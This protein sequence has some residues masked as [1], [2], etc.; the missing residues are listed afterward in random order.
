MGKGILI[1]KSLASVVVLMFI[2]CAVLPISTGNNS[3]EKDIN[4]IQIKYDRNHFNKYYRSESPNTQIVHRTYSPNVDLK[5]AI[6]SPKILNDG[7]L[8]SP[9]PLYCHDV[10]HT[11]R[12]PYNTSL[13]PYVEMWR[14]GFG[15]GTVSTAITIDNDGI[16]YV[17]GWDLYAFYPNGTL[18]WNFPVDGWLE[19]MCPAIADDGTI[20]VGSNTADRKFF[21][22]IN[23]NGT[24]KWKIGNGYM[25][26]TPIIADDGT[27]YYAQDL[28]SSGYLTAL[29][30]NGTEKWRY[31][32]SDMPIF[33]TP[34]LGE[35]GTIYFGSHDDYFYA[36]NPN[37]TLKWKYKTGAWIHCSPTIGDDGSIYVSS[38][39]D[40]LYAFYPNGTI[41]WELNLGSGA[42][43]A[44]VL[45]EDGT[46]Y[47][48]VWD[49]KFYAITP[50]GTVKWSFDCPGRVWHSS[51][52]LSADGFI[53]FGTTSA[54]DG[55]TGRLFALNR[56]G[57]EIWS[58]DYNDI[59]CPP[60]I[61]NRGNVYVVSY[62]D[63]W[64]QNGWDNWYLHAFGRG[65]LI[66]DANGP[67]S[68]Y[69]GAEV[70][71]TGTIFGGIPPYNF[72]WDF[73]DDG[74]SDEKNPTHIY[75]EIGEYIATFTV[76]DNE[77]NFSSDNATV[78]I[79]YPPPT[80]SI[81]KP[82]K[83]LYIMNLMIRPYL[84]DRK[85]VIFGLIN[86][87]ADAYHE[88]LGIERVEFYINDELK[89]TA[90]SAPYNWIWGIGHLIGNQHI[91]KVVAYDGEGTSASASIEV[92]KFL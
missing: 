21:Y 22:A 12:S 72:H 68:G 9:W 92:R 44:P 2:I 47:F 81:T 90:T 43:G 69:V 55:G 5:R 73:G 15:R 89:S 71:F 42:W 4:E 82:K 6:F 40:I 26:S 46:L 80:V 74:T 36:L 78:T 34:A 14:V 56:D 10:R 62:P 49:K 88:H 32:T 53:Y 75:N 54:W 25:E 29:Y 60:I 35:D 19:Q 83:A 85:P 11:G 57:E 50:N 61:D 84:L 48:G 52:T 70:Q 18:K 67:Y 66:V 17:P 64:K 87:K 28:W 16:I 27:I 31:Y 77:G 86:I 33:S 38:N 63:T 7:P 20:Y 59:H 58:G 24:L 65:P 8:D 13:N 79:V 76:I 23:S 1:R 91:V 30:P 45:D 41:K 37:G 39:D 3:Q 51:A